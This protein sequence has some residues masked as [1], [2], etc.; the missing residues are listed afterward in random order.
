MTLNLEQEPRHPKCKRS[1]NRPCLVVQSGSTSVYTL[2][3]QPL[4]CL[5]LVT[6]D[7]RSTYADYIAV[8][9]VETDS[10]PG[11]ATNTKTPVEPV[12]HCVAQ[13]LA[14]IDL[15][16]LNP[17]REDVPAR[18]PGWF[19]PFLRPPARSGTSCATYC[20]RIRAW[21]D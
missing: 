6:A 11:R 1:T 21:A 10:T 20:A 13:I 19:G 8:C 15:I 16:I 5:A 12:S 3:A 7:G 17:F 14:Q 2:P 18:K 4:P 9:E